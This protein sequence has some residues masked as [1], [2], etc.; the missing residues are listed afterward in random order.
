MKI[1][2]TMLPALIVIAFTAIAAVAGELTVG[3]LRCEYQP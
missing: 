1:V 3:E 2:A